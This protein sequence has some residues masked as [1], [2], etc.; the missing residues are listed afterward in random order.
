MDFY[1]VEKYL[2]PDYY[3][4]QTKLKH[5]YVGLAPQVYFS[6]IAHID[7]NIFITLGRLFN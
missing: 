1:L 7:V 4:K 6:F 5:S 3:K 2:R